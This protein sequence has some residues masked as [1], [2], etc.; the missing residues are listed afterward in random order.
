MRFGVKS[1]LK[2]L[3]F[4]FMN[5]QFVSVKSYLLYFT[6]MRA[7]IERYEISCNRILLNR[8]K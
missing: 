4:A 5:H 2:L 7:L 8:L 3:F 1:K 6:E